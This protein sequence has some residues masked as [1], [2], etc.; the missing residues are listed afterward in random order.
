MPPSAS[1]ARTM[2]WFGHRTRCLSS[3]VCLTR[4]SSSVGHRTEQNS[5]EPNRTDRTE[6]KNR[7]DKAGVSACPRC[8]VMEG[9]SLRGVSGFSS[10]PAPSSFRGPSGSCWRLPTDGGAIVD[11]GR[12]A[13]GQITHRNLNSIS[14]KEEV[15]ENWQQLAFPVREPWIALRYPTPV[16]FFCERQKRVCIEVISVIWACDGCVLPTDDV[17]KFQFVSAPKN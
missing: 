7:H 14:T 9:D 6:Q 5:T 12:N 4:L 8:A 1:D 16:A 17:C 15:R 2:L 3:G 11:D 13:G 10:R